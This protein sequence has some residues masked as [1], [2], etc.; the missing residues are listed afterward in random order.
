MENKLIEI[1]PDFPSR[2]IELMKHLAR[3]NDYHFLL[4]MGFE[5]GKQNIIQF[6]NYRNESRRI[7]G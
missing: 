5:T 3:N 7:S 1:E 2:K 6:H 4:A